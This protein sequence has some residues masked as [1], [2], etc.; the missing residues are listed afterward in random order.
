M[1]EKLKAVGT[2]LSETAAEAPWQ[3]GKVERKIKT[4]KYA[5]TNIMLHE[6]PP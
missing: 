4:F 1:Y 2:E 5:V 3:K 6:N